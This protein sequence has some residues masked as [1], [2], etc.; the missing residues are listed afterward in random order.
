MK[1]TDKYSVL[2]ALNNKELKRSSAQAM[3]RRYNNQGKTKS[4]EMFKDA[5]N[6]FDN[7]KVICSYYNKPIDN[8]TLYEL[9]K[10]YD[11]NTMLFSY[12]HCA[13]F[14]ILMVGED[15]YESCKDYTGVMIHPI[16][17]QVSL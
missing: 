11:I 2:E 12:Y 3:K 6:D 13:R 10:L 17:I 14:S 4:Y 7:N 16:E 1:Y 5:I 9:S 8:L 15:E